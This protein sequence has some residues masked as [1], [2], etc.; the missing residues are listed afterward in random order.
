MT[1][2]HA[3]GIVRLPYGVCWADITS[4]VRTEGMPE[5][6]VPATNTGYSEV[7]RM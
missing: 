6:I 3:N 2:R 1:T 4:E 5:G 7:E